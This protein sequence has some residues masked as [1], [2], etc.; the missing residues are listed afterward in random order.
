[1]NV[2]WIAQETAPPA[3]IDAVIFDVDGV[4]WE[5]GESY[6]RSVALTVDHLLRHRYGVADPRP[7]SDEELRL[8]RRAGGLNN[9]WHMTYV[10]VTLRLLGRADL[11][12]AAAESQGRGMA[13][14]E[15]LLQHQST[16]LDYNEVVRLFNEYYWGSQDFARHFGEPPRYVQDAPGCWHQEKQLI[17]DDLIEQLRGLGVRHF[18]IATG[19][20]WRELNTVLAAS[21]LDR[22]IPRHTMLTSD[23]LSKPDGRVL[24][25]VLGAMGQAAQERGEA[26][27]QA[28]LFCGDTRDDL[29]AVLNY[30]QLRGNTARWVGAVAVAPVHEHPFFS[31]NG[32]DAALEHIQDLP[33]LISQLGGRR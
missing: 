28:A 20:D 32:S 10:L 4:L 24:D 9:D 31:Q 17:P 7:V 11:A 18:G 19:R 1:L 25:W 5:T 14:A 15:E 8:F 12:Q 3:P 27:P 6:D 22:H 26:P 2:I 23:L 16:P 13:W 33:R 29:D 21:Q 30:R